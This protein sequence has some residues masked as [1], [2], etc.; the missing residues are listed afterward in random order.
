MSGAPSV[1]KEPV[2]LYNAMYEVCG[3]ILSDLTACEE[4][5]MARCAAK[6]VRSKCM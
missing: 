4:L 6:S 3:V 1:S 2:D 5:S